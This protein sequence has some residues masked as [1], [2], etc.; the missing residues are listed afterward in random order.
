MN[1]QPEITEATRQA[2]LQAFIDLYETMPVENITIRQIVD[3]AGYSRATF[4]NYF[5]DVYELLD[6]AENELIQILLAA[7]S[8]NLQTV[9]PM[10]NV[11]SAFSGLIERE[12]RTVRVFLGKTDHSRLAGKIY[13]QAMPMLSEQMGLS[14][15][16]ACTGYIIKYHI[17][18]VT[19]MLSEWL[20]AGKPVSSDTL[21]ELVRGILRDGVYATVTAERPENDP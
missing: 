1:K 3:R 6:A 14:R 9:D 2:F 17:A 10:E 12:E 21:A 7:V 18:G 16:S 11:S 4:Y 5:H 13:E 20:T 15:N 8:S 19:A